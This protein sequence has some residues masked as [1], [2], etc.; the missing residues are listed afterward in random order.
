M[1]GFA[2][3]EIAIGQGFVYA[4]QR[5][6]MECEILGGLKESGICRCAVRGI[7]LASTQCH[8]VR[9]SDGHEAYVDPRHLRKRRP[10]ASD[11]SA[12]RQAMPDCIERAKRGVG[13]MV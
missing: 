5:N 6:S 3:G 11:E 2:V 13:A 4:T 10:P 7:L 9:W 12:H 8:Y 1:S